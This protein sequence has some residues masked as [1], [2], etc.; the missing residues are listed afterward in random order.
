MARL[1]VVARWILRAL[2]VLLVLV[3][4]AVAAALWAVHASVPRLDG[5]L[6]LPGLS[7]PVTV[8]RDAIGTAVVKAANRVDAARALGFVHGQERFFEMDL[9]RRSAAGELSAL[10]GPIAVSRDQERR[11]HRLRARLTERLAQLS[12]EDRAALQAYADG[13]NAGVAQ[14]DTRPWQYLL[15]RAQPQPW[16]PTDSLL[17]VA[18]MFWTLQANSVEAGFERAL[19]RQHVGDALYDWL[20]PR[21]GRWDAALDG[22]ASPDLVLPGPDAIDLRKGAP[23]RAVATPGAESPTHLRDASAAGSGLDATLALALAPRAFRAP[24]AHE[25]APVFGSNNWAVA[26]A[27]TTSGHAMLADDMHLNIGTPGLW[28]RTQLEIGSGPGAIRAEGVTLPGMPFIVAGSN[29]HVAWGFTNA[30]GQWF[31][32]MRIPEGLPDTRLRTV[33]E[34]IEV[35]GA[36]P[37]KLPVVELDG[38]P[39]LRRVDGHSYALRWIGDQ[40]EAYNVRLGD[41]LEA[42]DLDGALRV[43]QTGGIP[44]Q[45]ILLADDQGRIA[46]TIAGQLWDQPAAIDRL[47]RFAALDA[48]APKWLGPSAYPVVKDPAA[49]Q[50]WTANN[51]QLG[52][53]GGALLGDGGFDLGAR[54]QQIRDRLTATPRHD[55]TT[56][57]AI[58]LDDEARF[59]GTWAARIQAAVSTTPSEVEVARLLASWNH[60]ADADQAA[61]RLVHDVRFRTLDALWLAWTTP[62]VGDSQADE[63]QRLEWHRMFEYTAAQALDRRPANLLPQPYSTWDEFLRAQVD[64]VVKDMTHDGARPLA[65]ATWGEE[66]ASRFHHV[67]ARAVP[68]L[69]RWLDL[70]AGP[71]SGDT[72][73]PRV[74]GPT[75]G[76]SERLVVAPG[77]EETATLVVAGGQSGHPMSPY[78]GAGHD[79]WAAGKTSPLL[80]GA[81]QHALTLEP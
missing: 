43:A 64:A 21:G 3:A 40:G 28:F 9:A 79:T 81:S 22:S 39:V 7:A 15:L 57:G 33:E 47:G 48:P 16:T 10:F 63:K 26:G 8:S 25:E 60:R 74:A 1:P 42:R 67:L 55:E 62:L 78:Y 52:G 35:K 65:Q 50:L 80:A 30:Y 24:A 23:P 56:L 37:V 66:N 73:M 36:A 19:L 34:T 61:Y 59:L 71:Q 20:E 54:A 18:E 49:G 76:Q 72:N 38:L 41:L 68:A 11:V 51:R 46:W 32:W 77:H 2:L 14:F 75:F 4:A 5:A 69:S 58:Q 6:K 13:V 12:A 45:N 27:R 53:A 70:P 29:G 31:D 44:H 17:V